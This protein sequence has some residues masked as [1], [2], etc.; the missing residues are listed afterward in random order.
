M[1][2]YDKR[3]DTESTTIKEGLPV[4]QKEAEEK[5]EIDYS[6]LT[7]LKKLSAHDITI[8]LNPNMKDY[9]EEIKKT[10][11]IERMNGNFDY[12]HDIDRVVAD[13]GDKLI[14]IYNTKEQVA[15]YRVK[16]IVR[17]FF[18]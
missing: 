4:Q 5:P 8:P 11:C 1:L 15:F 17:G 16:D 6:S 7:E 10:F 12:Y 18:L 3:Y 2:K 9:A 13:Q 14:H